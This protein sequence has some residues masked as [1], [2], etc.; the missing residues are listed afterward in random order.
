LFEESWRARPSAGTVEDADAWLW[1]GVYDVIFRKQGGQGWDVDA[2]G[3]RRWQSEPCLVQG[4]Q[5]EDEG[6]I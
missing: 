5:Q 4:R 1:E 6:G 3:G 2:D